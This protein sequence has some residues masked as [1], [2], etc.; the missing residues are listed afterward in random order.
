VEERER[1]TLG[2]ESAGLD[3]GKGF[4]WTGGR[5]LRILLVN[6]EG[7]RKGGPQTSAIGSS[8]LR[9]K[10]DEYRSFQG[11]GASREKR[12]EKKSGI[13]SRLV[14][15]VGKKKGQGARFQHKRKA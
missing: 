9:E 3:T 10:E 8:N 11:S 13:A 15:Q 5:I 1:R 2:A 4:F 6:D 12:K 7:E 14:D